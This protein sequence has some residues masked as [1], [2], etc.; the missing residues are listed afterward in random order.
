MVTSDLRIRRFS[1]MAEKVMNLIPGD[2]GRPI[3]DIKLKIILPNIEEIVHEVVATVVAKELEVRDREGRSYAVRVQP[4]KTTENKIDGAVIV[5]MD[6]DPIKRSISTVKD[7]SAFEAILDMSGEPLAILDAEMR[8]KAGSRSLYQ[9][10]GLTESSVGL[11]LFEIEGGRWNVKALRHRLQ[12]LAAEG[13]PFSKIA[14]RI[15]DRVC[16][17][18][19]RRVKSADDGPPLILL[20]I[21]T[22]KN[23]AR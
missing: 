1:A 11:S 10:F 20:S 16:L 19:A 13:E 5:F 22:V 12:R 15:D 9:A 18:S 6:N 14:I 4:Y 2:I 8:V 7:V 21:N 23:A 17:F 3:G